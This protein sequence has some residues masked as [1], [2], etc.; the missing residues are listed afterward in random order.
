M[1]YRL[2]LFAILLVAAASLP[3]YAGIGDTLGLIAEGAVQLPVSL[4]KIIGGTFKLIGDVL[5]FPF[6]A[7]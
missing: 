2:I 4:V 5:T 1:T 7:F 6:R 3:A